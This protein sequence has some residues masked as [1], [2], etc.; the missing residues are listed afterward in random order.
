MRLDEYGEAYVAF[1][2]GEVIG[3]VVFERFKRKLRVRGL[4]VFF[5]RRVPLADPC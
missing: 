4:F 3:R 1:R 5:L 2:H